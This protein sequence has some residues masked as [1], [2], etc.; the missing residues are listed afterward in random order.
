MFINSERDTWNIDP[1]ALE[2]TFELYPET[3]IVVIA[4]LY[5]TPARMDEL[6][7]VCR[8]HG[9]VIIEDAAESLE[10]TYKERPTGTFGDYSIISFSGYLVPA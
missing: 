3:K 10:A 6:E 8:T 2:K 4:H 7:A 1:V 9:A 5:G